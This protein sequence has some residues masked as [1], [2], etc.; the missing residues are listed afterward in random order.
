VV[1]VSFQE[2]LQLAMSKVQTESNRMSALVEDMMLLAR[3]DAGRPLEAV[4]FD[5]GHLVLEAVNDARVVDAQ[6]RYVVSL[7][8]EPLV[9]RGDERRL[10][11]VITNLLTNAR[12]HTPAGTTVAV[13]AQGF[14]QGIELVVHDDG[15]GLPAALQGHEFERFTRGD[16]SRTRLGE[17]PGDPAGS[18]LGLSIVQAIVE[19]H[20]GRVMVQSRPGDTTFVIRLPHRR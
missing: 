3:L 6:H 12:R 16:S 19:A 5:L 15:P 17:A 8:D 13:R 9:V 20:G 2:A 1:A 4:E 10:H 18:G 7:P 14:P 11:Q